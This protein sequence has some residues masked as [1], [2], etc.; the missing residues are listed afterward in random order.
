MVK[1]KAEKEGIN[2][3]HGK[4]PAFTSK[5]LWHFKEDGTITKM[6]VPDENALEIVRLIKRHRRSGK[7]YYAITK[8]LNQRDIPNKSGKPWNEITVK[9]LSRV[10]IPELAARG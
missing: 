3:N 6:L 8:Y 4:R 1:Q 7:S 10:P 9:K 5:K 2:L